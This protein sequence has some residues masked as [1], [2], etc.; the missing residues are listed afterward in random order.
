[1]VA[2]TNI[3]VYT[4]LH[5]LLNNFN[6]VPVHAFVPRVVQRVRYGEVFGLQSEG[7]GAGL[8]TSNWE[9]AAHHGKTP[10]HC[11]LCEYA[12]SDD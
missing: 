3:W 10:I 9:K 1:M 6:G 8:S 2:S 11:P 4:H 5:R 12:D 7:V